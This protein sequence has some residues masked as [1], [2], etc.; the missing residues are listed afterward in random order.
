MEQGFQDYW[1]YLSEFKI[2]PISSNKCFFLKRSGKYLECLPAW[3]ANLYMSLKE[4]VLH[5]EATPV[6]HRNEL[7]IPVC[8]SPMPV[9]VL[10]VSMVEKV[11][12]SSYWLQ[13]TS[14]DNDLQTH[15]TSWHTLCNPKQSPCNLHLIT[16]RSNNITYRV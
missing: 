7:W 12:L 14:K 4:K 3:E 11:D 6:L 15:E 13:K 8:K 10:H 5:K 9:P 16:Y 2:K 1:V